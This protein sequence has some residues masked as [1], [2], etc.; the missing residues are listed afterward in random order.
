MRGTLTAR[1]EKKQPLTVHCAACLHEWVCA[2]LPMLIAK[3][4]PLLQ[5]PCPKCG[6]PRV[7]EGKIPKRR[8]RASGGGIGF[9]KCQERRRKGRA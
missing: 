7:L 5:A 3:V 4:V 8:R 6:S 1:T 9:A 2:W